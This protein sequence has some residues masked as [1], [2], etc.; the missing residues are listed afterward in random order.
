MREFSDYFNVLDGDRSA[1]NA[2]HDAGMAGP[3]HQVC[4]DA[5]GTVLLVVQHAH[6]DANDG[7]DHDDFNGHG[8][9]ADDGA[10]RAVQKIGEDELIHVLA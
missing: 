7:Q 8:E 9:D 10:Q 2:V 6:E 5:V 3:H 1:T 4:A